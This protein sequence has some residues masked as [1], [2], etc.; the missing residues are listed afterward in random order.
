MSYKV[1]AKNRRLKRTLESIIS[2]LK[3]DSLNIN[4]P[5]KITLI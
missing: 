4:T 1:S 2:A 3:F 5:E